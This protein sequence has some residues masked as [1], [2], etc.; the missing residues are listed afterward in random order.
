MRQVDALTDLKRREGL[1]YVVRY[2]AL[3][4]DEIVRFRPDPF[5]AGHLLAVTRREAKA[6]LREVIEDRQIGRRD[7][8][9]WRLAHAP[10]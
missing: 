3:D 6:P 1:W 10:L 8:V 9:L 2:R 5:R 4:P 7:K